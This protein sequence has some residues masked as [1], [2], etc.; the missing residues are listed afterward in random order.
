METSVLLPTTL[1]SPD[2]EITSRTLK[3]QQMIRTTRWDCTKVPEIR[4]SGAWLEK[5]GFHYGQ[6]IEVYT[7][8]GKLVLIPKK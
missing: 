1:N 3:I 2:K 5:F 4:I 6:H 8:E 7:M